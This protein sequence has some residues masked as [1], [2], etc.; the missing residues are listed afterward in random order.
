MSSDNPQ[1]KHDLPAKLGQPALR[2]LAGVGIERLEQLTTRTEAE[3]MA[4]HGFGRKGLEMLREALQAK[5]LSF[6]QSEKG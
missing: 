1:V 6:K 2:A 4:L 3:L 5:G